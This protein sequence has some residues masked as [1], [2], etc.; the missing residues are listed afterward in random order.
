MYMYMYVILI[1]LEFWMD[2]TSNIFTTDNEAI[3][4]NE[5]K[6]SFFSA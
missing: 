1:K 5:D 3:L 4:N 6:I 2:I